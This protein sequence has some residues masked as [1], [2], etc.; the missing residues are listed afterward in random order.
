MLEA[1][2]FRLHLAYPCAHHVLAVAHK[3]PRGFNIYAQGQGIR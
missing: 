3:S 1:A 2:D